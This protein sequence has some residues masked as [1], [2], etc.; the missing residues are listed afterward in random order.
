MTTELQKSFQERVNRIAPDQDT[1]EAQYRRKRSKLERL[2]VATMVIVQMLISGGLCLAAVRAAR[3][4]AFGTTFEGTEMLFF[5]DIAVAA[6]L[7]WCFN[8]ISGLKQLS[9]ALVQ[10]LGVLLVAGLLHNFAFW[11]PHP[12]SI[13]FTGDW[14]RYQQVQATPNS[15][16]V[17]FT[18]IRFSRKHFDYEPASFVTPKVVYRD[19]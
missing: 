10:Q 15:A 16:F 11:M 8:K 19:R 3:A 7:C 18:Y 12:M 1:L 5:A 6:I 2:S 4:H 9:H 14:V 17:G 13:A